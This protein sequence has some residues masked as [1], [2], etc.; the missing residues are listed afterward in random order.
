MAGGG[1]IVLALADGLG[2]GP[3]AAR[4]AEL[5]M[6]C[7]AQRLDQSCADCL[8]ACDAALYHT[9]GVALALAQIDGDQLTVASVGNIRVLHLEA[10][11]SH[12][13][14]STS[15]IVGA[16]FGPLLPERR[17]LAAGDVLALYSDGFDETIPLRDLLHGASQP[18][19][20][21]AQ[22]ALERW[23]LARDDASMLLYRHAAAA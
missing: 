9:R 14:G 19:A 5:A 16:G 6:A 21:L 8:A 11:R 3:E 4:A 15:G 18:P 12:R 13:L 23:A 1:R 20:H 10:G 17:E 22:I 2:H 7:L